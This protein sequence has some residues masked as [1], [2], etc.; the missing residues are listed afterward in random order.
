LQWSEVR[1]F[2]TPVSIS[3]AEFNTGRLHLTEVAWRIPL[4]NTV[5][6]VSELERVRVRCDGLPKGALVQV[7]VEPLNNPLKWAMPEATTACSGGARDWETLVYFGRTLRTGTAHPIE[8]DLFTKFAVYAVATTR[9]LPV[10][11]DKHG[12]EP[13]E[14]ALVSRYIK[15]YSPKVYVVRTILATDVRV[16]IT[17]IGY[18]NDG[19]HFLATPSQRVSGSFETGPD[20]VAPKTPEVITLLVRSE[21]EDSWRVAGATLLTRVRG[22]WTITAAQVAPREGDIQKTLLVIALVTPEAF[23]PTKRV[24]EEMIAKSQLSISEELS[25]RISKE[26][27]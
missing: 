16:R 14:W 17:E 21:E 24:T 23:D 5:T 11:E 19:K 12:I 4:L 15:V 25:V 26:G 27:R 1:A 18:S 13:K 6:S 22:A 3:C 2:S 7:I 9:L 10:Y 20:Y 8:L